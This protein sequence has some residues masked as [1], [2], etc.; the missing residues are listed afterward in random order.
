M[1][2]EFHLIQDEQRGWQLETILSKLRAIEKKFAKPNA[3]QIVGMSATLSGLETLKS[4][5]HVT[6]VFE[7]THRPVPL[8]EYSLD[9]MSGILYEE[10]PK[11]FRIKSDEVFVEESP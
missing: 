11:A 8:S 9:A 5:L 4:W 6:S 10:P 1:I 2:D 3:F 7:C